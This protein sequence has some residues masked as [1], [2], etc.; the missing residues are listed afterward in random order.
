MPTSVGICISA[1]IFMS[2]IPLTGTSTAAK[3]VKSK[4]CDGLAGLACK[5][6]QNCRIG[7]TVTVNCTSR[8]GCP[9]PISK[10]SVEAVCRFCWQLQESDYDC[11][12][13]TN[14]STSSTKLQLTKCS[15]HSSVVCMGQRQFYK[16]VP[17]NWSSGYSWTKTMILSVVLGGFGADR[18]Y[19][20]LWKSAI[21]KLFSFGGLGVWTIV[22]V[23]LIAVGYIK[24]SDG[25]MYI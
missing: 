24:P 10:N 6:P 13:A 17:C 14:C 4:N 22:D 19:L 18:F 23:V 7:E 12:P 3:E 21:G 8:K 5:F 9:N 11:E 2:I 16:R 15:A 1:I 20:G 25:S